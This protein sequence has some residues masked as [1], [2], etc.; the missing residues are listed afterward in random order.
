MRG[1][2]EVGRADAV[3]I[4]VAAEEVFDSG[5]VGARRGTENPLQP[6]LRHAPRRGQRIVVARLPR[7][8]TACTAASS[9]AICA[10]DANKPKMRQVDVDTGA[11]HG[12]GR[13]DLD[14]GDA[15]AA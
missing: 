9:N 13:Q 14:A 1:G 2:G 15:G 5:A 6:C 7:T 3:L 10:E 12:G 4:D 8:A 11:A